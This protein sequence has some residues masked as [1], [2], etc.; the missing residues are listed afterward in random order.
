MR[1]ILALLLL[2]ACSHEQG[3]V[4]A[5][6]KGDTGAPGQDAT[7]VKTVQFCPSQGATTYGHFPEYGLCIG[8]EIYAVFWD[9]NNAF[10]AKVVPGTYTSTST[11]LQCTFTVAADCEVK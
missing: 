9:K 6:P 8:N 4:I 1:Y 2:N 5:G 3:T 11:G 10:L 7:P